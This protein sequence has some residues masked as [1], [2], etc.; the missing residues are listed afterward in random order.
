VSLDY[1]ISIPHFYCLKYKEKDKTIVL[2]I[3][4][5]DPVIYLEDTLLTAW[6]VPSTGE[7]L[8]I[9]EQKRILA[10]IYDYLVRQRGFKNVRYNVPE[11]E[12]ETD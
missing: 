4:F 5:R 7:R 2:E 12:A 8:T 3:D 11:E 9:A 1:E 10:N 6:E